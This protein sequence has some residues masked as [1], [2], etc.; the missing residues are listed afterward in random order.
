M[1]LT[2][3]PWQNK[4][5]LK[6]IQRLKKMHNHVYVVNQ[7]EYVVKTV[8]LKDPEDLLAF[9]TEVRV[10]MTPGIDVQTRDY[11]I[12]AKN[13]TGYIL[14]DH[15]ER[16]QPTNVTSVTAEQYLSHFVSSNKQMNAFVKKI[17]QRLTRFYKLTGRFHGDLHL[18]NIMVLLDKQNGFKDLKIIDYGNTVPFF[19]TPK[20]KTAKYEDYAKA[21][22]NTFDIH[23]A[24]LEFFP[25][26]SNV[27]VKHNP[28]TG[29]PFRANQNVLQY[30]KVV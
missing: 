26:D 15:V 16:N 6:K 24:P 18:D 29:V 2:K 13:K 22:R 17:K 8:P 14:M 27:R 21:V 4:N 7:N 3:V 1:N 28:V 11:A 30:Y 25:V 20:K 10:G 5:T 12:V 19:T 23:H 9:Y